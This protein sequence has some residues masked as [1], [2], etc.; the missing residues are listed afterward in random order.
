MHHVKHYFYVPNSIERNE[1]V[2][3]III[4]YYSIW[5]DAIWA[6]N[7]SW[8]GNFAKYNTDVDLGWDIRNKKSYS[9]HISRFN[10]EIN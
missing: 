7:A 6:K 10:N 3:I 4:Y 1:L 8:F 9:S 2:T 5:T